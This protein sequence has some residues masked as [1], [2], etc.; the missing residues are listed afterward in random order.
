MR[1]A[2]NGICGDVTA[3][4]AVVGPAFTRTGPPAASN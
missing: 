4:T 1:Y 3:T 2:A